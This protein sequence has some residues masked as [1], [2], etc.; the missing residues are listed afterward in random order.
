MSELKTRRSILHFRGPRGSDSH[1]LHSILQKDH[2]PRT[3]CWLLHVRVKSA[4]WRVHVL[5]PNT[6]IQSNTNCRHVFLGAVFP[7]D[8][9]TSIMTCAEETQNNMG[10]LYERAPCDS[11]SSC[12]SPVCA[13]STSFVG[14]SRCINFQQ[15]LEKTSAHQPLP[16]ISKKAVS[17]NPMCASAFPKRPG[18]GPVICVHAT[19]TK[20]ADRLTAL[21]MHD[22]RRCARYRGHGPKS[23]AYTANQSR[24][25]C[26]EV[27]P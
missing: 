15:C 14:R 13:F 4:W 21:R 23:S 2:T 18:H 10:G 7:K 9:K 26:V 16:H 24:N 6:R 20:H 25:P 27:M 17:N 3:C 12:I 11:T 1:R 19:C 8:G 5:L 22:P